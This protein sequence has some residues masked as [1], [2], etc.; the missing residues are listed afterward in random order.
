M[1]RTAPVRRRR[2]AQLRIAGIL[3]VASEGDGRV[4]RFTIMLISRP[5]RPAF[6]LRNLGRD[7]AG[8]KPNGGG[9]AM[10]RT[11]HLAALLG[12]AACLVGAAP[13]EGGALPPASAP[14]TAA[15][16]Y[17]PPADADDG[18]VA[19]APLAAPPG[20]PP[21]LLKAAATA[22]E[23]YPSI[24]N[25]EAELK[26]SRA[27]LRGAR[28]A[29]FPTLTLEALALTRG[30]PDVPGGGLTASITGEQPIY[31][32]GRIEGTIDRAQATLL[33]RSAAVDETAQDL[34]LAVSDAFFNLALAARHQAVLE[35][36]LAQHRALLQTIQNRV[37]Q[38]VSPQA[39]LDLAMSRTAQLEQD[40]EVAKSQRKS[41]LS[42]LVQ[43][44]GDPNTDFGN[45][46]EYD[47]VTMHPQDRGAI[48]Q[49]L[50][51]NPHLARLRSQVL[52]AEADA[53]VA[54]ASIMPQLLGQVAHDDLTGTR[55]GI[56]LRAQ[57]GPGLSQF[58]AAEAAKTRV[59]A[60]VFN[61]ATAERELRDALQVDFVNN[62][63]ARERV[64][65][66]TQAALTA[67]LVT[68]SYRRQFITGRRTWLD[69][70]NASRE[71]TNS[72]IAVADAETAAMSSNAHIWLRTCGW[73][74]RPIDGG[75]E[76]TKK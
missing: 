43:L 70:M 52:I 7:A 75:G 36:G 41:S 29:R 68:E 18:D 51:C 63:A 10:I 57:T 39:D 48:A 30:N 76:G 38:E 17:G 73:Q 69:V 59:R 20:I 21:A 2:S 26:A 1:R 53:R 33:E 35:D 27:D 4:K 54:K 15:P 61:V 22:T 19:I 34:A 56:V 12:A 14:A 28:W 11:V 55:A 31:T 40:L 32:F 72:Q 60:A 74:P 47:E 71:E 65:A 58:T 16:A 62:R 64:K 6:V 67:Q 45:V 46:P 37:R 9:P 24:R 13:P 8:A 42:Q 50:N 3:P 25:A 44:V 5:G 49:A 23:N 66:T